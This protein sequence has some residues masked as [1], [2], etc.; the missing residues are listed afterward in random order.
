VTA[1]GFMD[2]IRG[3]HMAVMKDEAI[4]CFRNMGHFDSEIMVSWLESNPE[5]REENI[6]PQPP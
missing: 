6:K 5:I 4:L 2:V 1:T 3:E